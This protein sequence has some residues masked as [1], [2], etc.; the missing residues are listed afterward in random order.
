MVST[1]G[2]SSLNGSSFAF[3]DDDI[4]GSSAPA[5]DASLTSPVVNTLGYDSV[6]V[7]FDYYYRHVTG[8]TGYVEGY[9]GTT[10]VVI[11]SFTGTQGSWTSAASASYDVT[12]MANADFQVR[13]RFN[14]GGAWGW[15]WAVDNFEID[16]NVLP[17]TNVRVAITT[18]IFG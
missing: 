15:Y 18:D 17:C 8:Q 14:D 6:T 16:G 12:A 1:Y 2:G 3:L 10:W 4:V 9:N 7:S 11:D 13:F 5:V